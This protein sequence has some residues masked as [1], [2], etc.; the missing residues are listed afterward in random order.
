MFGDWMGPVGLAAVAIGGICF[1]LAHRV[2]DGALREL[3]ESLARAADERMSRLDRAIGVIAVAVAIY[4]V[5]RQL[6][7]GREGLSAC[8][9]ILIVNAAVVAILRVRWFGEIGAPPA[10][11][12]RHRW[13]ALVQMAGAWIGF[14]GCAIYLLRP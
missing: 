10:L 3:P 5:A 14:A 1:F 11:A 4:Y 12:A 9:A 7:H 13:G 8:V 2:I 6:G